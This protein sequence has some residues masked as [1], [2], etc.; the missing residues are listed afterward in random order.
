[1]C[2]EAH[3]QWG[4]TETHDNTVYPHV[5]LLGS[6]YLTVAPLDDSECKQP[7]ACRTE[8]VRAHLGCSIVTFY[9]SLLTVLKPKD[10]RTLILNYVYR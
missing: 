7:V 5:F 9:N 10:P 4:N 6:V 8:A 3:S 2:C 1:M